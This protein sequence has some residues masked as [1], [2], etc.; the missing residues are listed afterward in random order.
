MRSLCKP[1]Y[2]ISMLIAS[3]VGLWMEPADAD[4]A[5]GTRGSQVADVTQITGR[6][7]LSD[8]E[9]LQRIAGSLPAK[10]TWHVDLNSVGGDVSAA[11]Q[12]GRLLRKHNAWVNVGANS[13][14]LSA[15]VFLLAGGVQ[16][17]VQSHLGARVG[18]HRP[19]RT[20]DDAFTLDAQ[21][22]QQERLGS[23]IKSFL[24]DVNI[25][26]ALYEQMLLVAPESVRVLS[27][28]ELRTLGLNLNDPNW[29]DARAASEARDIGI[30]RAEY[31]ARKAR[32]S[33][34][35]PQYARPGKFFDDQICEANVLRGL[36]P[37]EGLK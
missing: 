19:Y 28:S 35:C 31:V 2:L 23:Q 36:P 33:S 8:Y 30:T 14:C 27:P 9:A 18:I 12:I 5:I 13:N 16:R 20:V 7:R 32:A 21:R 6:I 15:C 11:L 25:T 26:G 17:S 29:D 22:T 3:V 4:V 10:A 24:S 34:I 37:N 1:S